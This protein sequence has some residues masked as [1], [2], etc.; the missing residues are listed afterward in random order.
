MSEQAEIQRDVTRVALAAVARSGF[1]LAGAGAIREHGL[2]NRPTE[3]VDL[4]T[5]ARHAAAFDDAVE[6]VVAALRNA[7]YPVTVV[8]R[9][10]Q[11]ARLH[12]QSAGRLVLDV[13]LGVDWRADDPVSL[14]VG[15]VLALADAVGNKVSALY[16]RGEPRDYLDVDTIRASGL[17]TDEDLLTAAG[18]RD[19]GFE[20]PMFV[21]RLDAARRITNLDVTRYGVTEGQLDAVKARFAA[22]AARLR[23]A[24]V[25]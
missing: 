7:G 19:A 24:P 22:W 17:F 15:P 14:D 6:R 4:F 2:T 25:D 5:T 11:F 1:A 8:R 9:G 21:E 23:G 18:E 3:D 20:V 13:D 12:L 16:S 10:P